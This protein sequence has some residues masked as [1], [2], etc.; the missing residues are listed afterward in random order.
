MQRRRLI[1]ERF[2]VREV[3]EAAQAE[4]P[5]IRIPKLNNLH[6]WFARR[7]CGVAR[8]LTL[9]AVLPEGAKEA[10]EDLTGLSRRNTTVPFGALY[11]FHPPTE[12]VSKVLERLI[13][14]KAEEIAVA[15]PMAGGGAIPLESLRLGFRTIAADYNPVS[16]LILRASV[17]F[18]A[19]FADKGLFERTLEEARGM[20]QWARE[21]LGDLYAPDTEGYILARG[22]TCPHCKGLVPIVGFGVEITKK[23]WIGKFLRIEFDGETKGFEAQCVDWKPNEWLRRRKG[24]VISIE[25]PYCGG[26]FALRGRGTDHAFARWFREHAE[27]MEELIE[28][29]RPAEEVIE[30]LMRLHIPLVKQV[31]F[32]RGNGFVAV[33]N[34]EE[35]LERFREAIRR[36]A[37]EVQNGDLL[38]FIPTDPIPDENKWA[39]TARNLGLT[40]WYMLYNPRQL[41]VLAKL[42]QYIAGRAEE[43]MRED[44]EF[45]AAIAFY[46]TAGIDKIMNYNTIGTSWHKSRAILSPVLRGESTLDFRNEYCEAITP[47]RNIEWAFEPDVAESGE[48][49]RTSGG[50]LP[51]LRAL[52]D[53]FRGR[54]FGDRVSVLLADATEFSSI[55]G[56]DV[57]DVI[58]VDPPYFEQVVYSDKI[59]FIWAFMRRALSPALDLLFPE[60]RIR[61]PW[62]PKGLEGAELPRKRE[63]V[64]RGKT[65][66]ELREEDEQVSNWR[67]LFKETCEEFA[68][69]LKDDGVLVLWFTHPSD[70]AWRSVGEALYDAGLVV[71][72]VYP[73]VSEMPTR[74]RGQ[75]NK[76]AQQI[77][78]AIVAR[79][80]EGRERLIA[81]DDMMTYLRG[82]E[83]FRSLAEGMAK[84]ALEMAE[85]TGL[86]T[87]DA[88]ALVLGTA[89]SV[90][91]RFEAPRRGVFGELYSA[92]VTEV[93]RMFVG[94]ILYELLT[95]FGFLRLPKEEAETVESSIR[96][97]MLFDP[98]TRAYISLLI[99][100]RV[101]L[102][103]KKLYS[104]NSENNRGKPFRDLD[105]DFAQT[106]SKLCGFDLSNLRG[107]GLVNEVK[108]DGKAYRPV[109]FEAMMAAS[110]REP[111]RVLLATLPGRAIFASYLA[112]REPGG[113]D[114]RAR[115][116]TQRFREEMREELPREELSRISSLGLLLLSILSHEEVLSVV[117]GL[118]SPFIEADANTIRSAAAEALKVLL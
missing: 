38:P 98:A 84:E 83:K 52:C 53:W 30:S 34:D 81:V 16:Y 12:R 51:V 72:K 46:L 13:G 118:P 116:I 57:L 117:E 78:L 99:P 19:K 18:P 88:F 101:D 5:F 103:E 42:A 20:I 10:F 55:V 107:A 95:R 113:P 105:F 85:G 109:I 104:E 3:N 11:M 23:N 45:G 110:G 77:S 87:V 31:R 82:E 70:I 28:G 27:L 115:V 112:A 32:E 7:I 41:Y 39:Q 58:N 29:F 56:G 25:C 74:Y 64:V 100:S 71:S 4:A 36:L 40:K 111:L 47:F 14:K 8:C 37:D 96:D 35:E 15:D 69:A 86:S 22:V 59:E 106:V 62:S 24:A 21:N 50:I 67:V 90:A 61:I 65:R 93:I 44:P 60:E 114:I 9:A 33:A 75:V 1:E 76:V 97:A 26:W 89:L 6:P 66:S 43:L 80:G 17:E 94:D 73:M 63:M 54:G 102:S 91:T 108:G 49:R 48:F 79:K 68:K 2:P 92:A